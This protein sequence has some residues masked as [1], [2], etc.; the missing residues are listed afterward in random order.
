MDRAVSRERL[1]LSVS[2]WNAYLGGAIS[3]IYMGPATD[4]KPTPTPVSRRPSSSVP[5]PDAAPINAYLHHRKRERE[6][7][8]PQLRLGFPEMRHHT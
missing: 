3:A 5:N 4:T 8:C 2:G 6:R 7:P 1:S